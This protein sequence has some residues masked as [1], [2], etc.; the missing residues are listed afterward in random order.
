VAIIIIAITMPFR[1]VMQA[2][3]EHLCAKRPVIADVGSA[4]NLF[5]C[6]WNEPT[7]WESQR[8]KKKKSARNSDDVD[9]EKEFDLVRDDEWA[10][11]EEGET[12]MQILP[13]G[14]TGAPYRLAYCDS[15]TA[16]EELNVLIASTKEFF[17]ATLENVPIPWR[18]TSEE[19]E[20]AAAGGRQLA[21]MGAIMRW[22]GVHA[23]GTPVALD[24]WDKIRYQKPVNKMTAKLLQKRK[25][26]RWLLN[27]CTSDYSLAPGQTDFK[28]L[29]LM[30]HFV[31]EQ[32]SPATRFAVKRNFYN[33]DSS[34]SGR[35]AFYQ[36]ILMWILVCIV[37]AIMAYFSLEWSSTNGSKTTYAWA[38]VILVVW[39]ADVFVNELFQIY[40]LS[41]VIEKLRPQL[42]Q[43][44]RVLDNVM[45]TRLHEN[46]TPSGDIRYVQHISAAC[47]AA[48][49]PALATLESAHLLN[50]LDDSDMAICRLKMLRRTYD[51]GFFSSLALFLPSCIKDQPVLLQQFALDITLPL[52][53]CAFLVLFSVLDQVSPYLLLAVVLFLA[54]VTVFL[55]CVVPSAAFRKAVGWS[56]AS[57]TE[58]DINHLRSRNVMR[59]NR[60]FSGDS[61][62]QIQ[63]RALNNKQT[64]DELPGF[65]FDLVEFDREIAEA[66]LGDMF[67]FIDVMGEAPQGKAEKDKDVRVMAFPPENDDERIRNI[68]AIEQAGGVHHPEEVLDEV[69]ESEVYRRNSLAL[70]DREREEAL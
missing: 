7:P 25:Q 3:L 14:K 33:M 1:R 55:M 46:Y 12:S 15:I 37:Y 53:A 11:Q 38:L 62:E 50:L 42:M 8:D 51:I 4:A 24:F 26:S 65:Q 28:D 9:S 31:L 20:E 41:S 57:D 30:Q 48:R 67:E 19:E 68:R 54:L 40:F 43:I 69:R 49:M 36:W 60:S 64:H 27:K 6:M 22:M 21:L 34:S 18:E 35:L 5:C 58:D 66:P 2:V 70:T 10:D 63:F 44:Y 61:D 13:L 16:E 59:Y 17:N 39:V 45:R 29:M 32:L 52:V 23:D 56:D 47:R